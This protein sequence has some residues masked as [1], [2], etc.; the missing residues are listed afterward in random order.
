MF[1]VQHAQISFSS[2][3]SLDPLDIHFTQGKRA[4]HQHVHKRLLKWSAGWIP[5]SRLAEGVRWRV[6]DGLVCPLGRQTWCG[7]NPSL[8]LTWMGQHALYALA[9]IYCI[10]INHL[11]LAG[12]VFSTFIFLMKR[13]HITVGGCNLP[14]SCLQKKQVTRF[15]LN[16]LF[17]FNL[18]ASHEYKTF[19]L[20]R[21][22][23]FIH[24]PVCIIRGG[25]SYSFIFS[26]I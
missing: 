21:L 5:H 9:G 17:C 19:S 18:F 2:N 6:D 13:R 15:Y 26:A 4:L 25:Y 24:V 3:L 16:N 12:C 8:Q 7:F 20:I 1:V 22:F 10:Y 23:F 11:P 14:L